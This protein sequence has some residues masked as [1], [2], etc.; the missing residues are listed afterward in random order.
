MDQEVSRVSWK[1]FYVI[2]SG[3]T[4]GAHKEIVKNLRGIGQIEVSSPEDSD[5]LVVFCPIASRVGADIDEA[6]NDIEGDKPIILVVMHHT[7]SPDHV[8]ADSRRQ[9][10]NP[11]VH[12]TVD[13]FFHEGRFLRCD[14]NEIARSEIQRFLEAPVYEPSFLQFII[15]V[16]WNNWKLIVFVIFLF[17]VVVVII[18]FSL[19]MNRAP[20][21]QNS[22]L[23]YYHN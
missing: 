21:E 2:V 15:R 18:I 5:Y 22:T 7:F 12:L 14:R 17:M 11:N 6:L 16:C 9:V 1:K 20:K 23:Q 10:D 19:L 4:S 3:N 13:C 8:V